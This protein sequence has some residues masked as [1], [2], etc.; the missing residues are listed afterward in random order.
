MLAIHTARKIE[1]ESGDFGVASAMPS[2][3]RVPL[4]DAKVGVRYAVFA[5]PAFGVHPES[6]SE[7]LTLR[8]YKGVAHELQRFVFRHART[9]C[10][11]PSI[12]RS[13]VF[14]DEGSD[15]CR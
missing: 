4:G 2:Q 3:M 6:G 7:A 8:V 1:N 9:A 5:D 11:A 14:P 12:D 13:L 15:A 10:G